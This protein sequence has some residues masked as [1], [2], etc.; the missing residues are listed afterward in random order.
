MR[1]LHRAQIR[2]PEPFGLPNTPTDGSEN[3][4]RPCEDDRRRHPLHVEQSDQNGN[5]R[6]E[7]RGLD[8]GSGDCLQLIDAHARIERGRWSQALSKPVLNDATI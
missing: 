5:E 8:I 4:D 7:G 2:E 1:P 3:R 6:I